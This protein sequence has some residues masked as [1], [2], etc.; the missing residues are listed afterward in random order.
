MALRIVLIFLFL[1]LFRLQC[2]AQI[3]WS[4]SAQDAGRT[5]Q[6][7][8][9]QR[10]GSKVAAALWYPRQHWHLDGW[11]GRAVCWGWPCGTSVRLPDCNPVP[12]DPSGRQVGSRTHAGST[13]LPTWKITASQIQSL[14]L[15]CWPSVENLQAVAWEAR[16]LHPKAE[17]RS[18]LRHAV[19][20]HLWKHR[21]HVCPKGCLQCH[22][23]Q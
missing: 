18:G 22:L 23:K 11:C 2:L 15:I 17:G 12:E 13:N 8:E 5:S 19:H 14:A 16:C 1:F 10:P 3:L 21:H 20:H 6:G 7:S 4:V 9:Q